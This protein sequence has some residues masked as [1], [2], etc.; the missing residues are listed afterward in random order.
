MLKS[1]TGYLCYK[2]YHF[3][4]ILFAYIKKTTYLCIMKNK[5]KYKPNKN[6][7][8][9]LIEN[10]CFACII[11]CIIGLIVSLTINNI[12][13]FIFSVLFMFAFWAIALIDMIRK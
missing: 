7:M 6:I 4:L 11:I 10:I 9:D 5:Q 3:Y 13:T 1:Y 8:K 2:T 12:I